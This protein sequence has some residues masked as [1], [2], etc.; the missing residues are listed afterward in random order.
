[1]VVKNNFENLDV[2][3]E[4]TMPDRAYYVP[5]SEMIPDPVEHREESDRLQFLNGDWAFRYYDSIREMED[6]FW[7][8]D[9]DSSAF[10]KIHVPGMWQTQGFDQ[11]QYVNIRYPFPVDPPYVPIDNPC[12]ACHAARCQRRKRQFNFGVLSVGIVPDRN[13]RHTLSRNAA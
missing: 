1:M 6:R 12:G 5:A 11:H 7:L 3:H 10:G 2:L 8:P 13:L 9:F 4:N